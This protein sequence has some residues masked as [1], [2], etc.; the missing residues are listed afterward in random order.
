MG[1]RLIKGTFTP[2]IGEPDGD[3]VRFIADDLSNWSLLEG[4]AGDPGRE[5][6]MQLRFEGI[7]SIEKAATQ[8]LARNSRDSMLTLIGGPGRPRGFILAKRFEQHGRPVCFTFAGE[9]ADEDGSDIFLSAAM[10]EQS[11]NFQQVEAGFAYPLYYNTLFRDLREKFTEAVDT[12]RTN[13]RGYWTTDASM[14]GVTVNSRADLLTIP[15]VWPKLWR[16]LE[17]FLR[18]PRSLAGF[19]A[20]LRN[21]RERA[22]DL[23]TFEQRSIDHFFEVTGNQ[24]RMNIAPENLRVVSRD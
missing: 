12:A 22:D 3:S 8:P 24:V 16:R 6:S 15:P 23:T 18:T 1:F 21:T 9:S 2:D 5:D 19:K 7:D 10:L 4:E 11:V 13:G 14:T 17:E 20:F